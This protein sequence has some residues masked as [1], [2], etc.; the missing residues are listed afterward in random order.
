[1]I[2]RPFPIEYRA[3]PS[4]LEMKVTWAGTSPEEERIADLGTPFELFH[5]VGELGGLAGEA[6]PPIE[7]S[8]QILIVARA[9]MYTLVASPAH[10]SILVYSS[11]QRTGSRYA[12]QP[13]SGAAVGD[14]ELFPRESGAGQPSRCVRTAT[15]L[16]HR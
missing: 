12:S 13:L 5:E 14:F 4:G 16:I 10:E 7:S 1:M 9:P 6:I 15:F 2:K 3:A 8:R 11:L